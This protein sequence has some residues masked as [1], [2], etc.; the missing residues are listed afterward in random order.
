MD[1]SM[2][3]QLTLLLILSTI[4]FS[5]PFDLL[6]IR[7]GNHLPTGYNSTVKKKRKIHIKDDDTTIT[8]SYEHISS[9]T[10]Y[11]TTKFAVKVITDPDEFAHIH[12]ILETPTGHMEPMCG[13]YVYF[14][15]YKNNSLVNNFR[16][17]TLCGESDPRIPLLEDYFP[18][19]TDSLYAFNLPILP[20]ESI[21]SIRNTIDENEILLTDWKICYKHPSLKISMSIKKTEGIKTDVYEEKVDSCFDAFWNYIKNC[22]AVIDFNGYG[23]CKSSLYFGDT[24]N[25]TFWTSTGPE[26]IKNVIESK[27]Y[28]ISIDSIS[29]PQPFNALLLSPLQNRKATH[30]LSSIKLGEYNHY[31]VKERYESTYR[32]RRLPACRKRDTLQSNETFKPRTHPRCQSTYADA[33]HAT[34]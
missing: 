3:K 25:Y 17:N 20:H 26:H 9:D 14:C 28:F 19:S 29:N 10:T 22:E 12:T 5:Q 21:D 16:L 27:F 34:H 1:Y 32:R 30:S 33:T 2:C 18:D 6:V 4:L 23:F 13:E 7:H 24:S 15:F 31:Y 8:E 11:D